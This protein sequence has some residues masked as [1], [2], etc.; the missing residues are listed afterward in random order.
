MCGIVGIHGAQES[1]WI[2]RM[3]QIQF[4][5]GPDGEGSYRDHSCELSLAMRRLSI[6]DH[7]GG[8]SP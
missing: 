4:H 2:D 7:E 1:E 5:R 8:V 6:V 3:N